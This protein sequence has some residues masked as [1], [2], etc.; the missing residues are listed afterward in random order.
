MPEITAEYYATG[1]TRR[2]DPSTIPALIPLL[3]RRAADGEYD[4]YSMLCW[5]RGIRYQANIGSGSSMAWDSL[6]CLW[7]ESN[8]VNGKS[9]DLS[10]PLKALAKALKGEEKRNAQGNLGLIYALGGRTKDE[11]LV[12]MLEAEKQYTGDRN[13]VYTTSLPL[14]WLDQFASRFATEMTAYTRGSLA[15]DEYVLAPV[16]ARVDS[17][18]PSRYSYYRVAKTESGAT[19]H[20]KWVMQAN[21]LTM[22]KG[23]LRSLVAMFIFMLGVLGI[24]LNKPDLKVADGYY[25]IWL[26]YMIERLIRSGYTEFTAPK[27]VDSMYYF[28]MCI[29]RPR[30]LDVPSNAQASMMAIVAGLLV[31]VQRLKADGVDSL[32]KEVQSISSAQGRYVPME[33]T[34]KEAF[35]GRFIPTS[36]SSGIP[37]TLVVPSLGTVTGIEIIRGDRSRY[38]ELEPNSFVRPADINWT[39][40]LQ[41]TDVLVMNEP[42]NTDSYNLLSFAFSGQVIK[43]MPEPTSDQDPLLILADRT[44]SKVPSATSYGV[45]EL[46]CTQFFGSTTLF[47][48]DTG[49]FTSKGRL[50]IGGEPVSIRL[51]EFED[52]MDYPEVEKPPQETEVPADVPTPEEEG[53]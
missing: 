34:I 10:N 14:D 41:M 16:G 40:T 22:H 12:A 4:M 6:H 18:F 37:M 25:S 15:V 43:V 26:S 29:L 50:T 24:P 27:W 28:M 36:A 35:N 42:P 39:P 46:M 45:D 30:L 20:V 8:Y 53:A 11:I 32:V 52:P 13:G 3:G 7:V 23:A 49:V 44:K 2:P 5:S 51:T 19:R 38:N 33:M 1:D 48:G 17:I 47:Q 9:E 21:E 31:T